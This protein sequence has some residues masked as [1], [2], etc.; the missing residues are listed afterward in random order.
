MIAMAWLGK[1]QVYKRWMTYLP[2][3]IRKNLKLKP[4]DQLEY[5]GDGDK[6]Y[7]RRVEDE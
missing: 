5:L 4:G 2:K 1:S 3:V 7:I 6:V